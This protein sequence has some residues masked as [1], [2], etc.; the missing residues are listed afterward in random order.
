[1]HFLVTPA[2]LLNSLNNYALESLQIYLRLMKF[3]SFFQKKEKKKEKKKR[4]KDR[5]EGKETKDKKE[6]RPFDRE[7]DLKTNYFDD[8][9]KR[10]VIKKASGISSRFGKGA[11]Q[12]L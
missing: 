9:M 7:Q 6:R 4:K 12:Y 5:K 2:K 3:S 8:A 10:S 11:Q 1:M